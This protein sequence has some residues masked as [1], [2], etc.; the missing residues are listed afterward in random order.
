[1]PST[2]PPSLVVMGV[3]G[4]GKS[5][6][7]RLLA[8]NLDRRYVEG[9]ELHPPR[10]VQRMAAGIALT[11]EDRHGW[12]QTIAHLLREARDSARPVVVTCSALKRSYRDLLRT[13]DADLRFVFLH[14]DPRLLA[15]RMAARSGH[16]MPAS[17]LDSQLATLEPP[18]ADENTIRIDIATSTA[19]QLE[20][21]IQGLGRD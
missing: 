7:G 20:A 11:D 6:L 9:D 1:M 2:S 19:A 16:Y 13:G 14:G 5:T 12:L 17:L 8:Q 3:S 15:Q 18:G 21:A 4:C 10:N